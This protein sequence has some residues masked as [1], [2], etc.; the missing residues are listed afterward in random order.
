VA[1]KAPAA[2]RQTVS[3]RELARL[4]G[5]S[6]NRVTKYVA[7]GLPSETRG[8]G[9]PAAFDLAGCMRWFLARRGSRSTEDERQRYF[10]LQG[11]KIEQEIRHRAGELVEAAD[12][13][14]RWA[15]MVTAARERLLS[16]P[17]TAVQRGLVA[18]AHEDEL[19][20][21]VHDALRELAGGSGAERA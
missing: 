18:A 9:K 14:R 5:V 20:A 17:G 12:V 7:D 8:P 21:L 2:A 10:R 11:D 19:I 1:Q 15:G 6:A 13:E 16:L 4:L 3:R